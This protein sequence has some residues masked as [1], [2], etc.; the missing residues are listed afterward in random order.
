MKKTKYYIHMSNT[1][2]L[3]IFFSVLFY[4][5]VILLVTVSSLILHEVGHVI[6]CRLL[7]VKIGQIH[8]HPHGINILADTLLNSKKQILV[9][10]SGPLFSLFISFL[11]LA[12]Y[13]AFKIK[14]LRFLSSVNFLLFAVNI[15]P[16]FPLDGG[17]LLRALICFYRGH[18]EAV[19]T[20]KKI[21]VYVF[22]AFF[23][24]G[25][26]IS[27]SGS[28]NVSLSVFCIVGFIK[29]SNCGVYKYNWAAFI[30]SDGFTSNSKRL[31]RIKLNNYQSLASS[32]KYISCEYT[33]L[34]DIFDINGNYLKTYTQAEILKE[35]KIIK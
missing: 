24:L 11:F 2:V 26:I 23:L 31:R 28:F 29:L 3:L 30:L 14:F 18:I 34:A 17:E 1:S 13:G 4:K 12:L 5:E 22:S 9:S 6:M 33:L 10:I 27:F 20:V 8:I 25:I 16:A 7:N 32:V 19:N 35:I 15:V 21:S